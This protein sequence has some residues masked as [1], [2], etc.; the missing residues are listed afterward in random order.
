MKCVFSIE[1]PY[2]IRV[3]SDVAQYCVTRRTCCERN[4]DVLRVRCEQVFGVCVY[5]MVKWWVR[6]I[7]AR[8]CLSWTNKHYDL[9]DACLYIDIWSVCGSEN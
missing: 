2:A 1:L 8:D 6:I 3:M 5:I 4:E 7:C 9:N